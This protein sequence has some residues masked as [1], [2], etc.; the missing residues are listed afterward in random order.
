MDNPKGGLKKKKR[1]R[2]AKANFSIMPKAG[3][4]HPHHSTPLRCSDGQTN[5]QKGYLPPDGWK[6][7]SRKFCPSLKGQIQEIKNRRPG[8]NISLVMKIKR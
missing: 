1:K 4:F 7:N 5:E 2:K 8:V 6:P 3:M